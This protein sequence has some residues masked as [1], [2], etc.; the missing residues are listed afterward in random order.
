MRSS[1]S[2]GQEIPHFYVPEVGRDSAV[3]IATRYRLDVPGIQ[4]RWGRDLP[5]PSRP[6]LGPTQ[7]PIQWVSTSFPEV[8]RP[9]HGVNHPSH[10]ASRL[11]KEYSYNSTPLLSLR[12]LLR[13]KF[14]FI[15]MYPARQCEMRR[16]SKTPHRKFGNSH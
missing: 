13:V 2:A 15:F 11:R 3:S 10:L 8:K 12:G 16:P 1:V 5:H 7:P 6:A 4:S 14:A 9:G